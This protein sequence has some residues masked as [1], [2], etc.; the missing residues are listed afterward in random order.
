MSTVDDASLVKT[1]RRLLGY[2]QADLAKCL[3]AHIM[4]VSRWERNK[5]KLT[6]GYRILLRMLLCGDVEPAR[7]RALAHLDDPL[8]PPVS[9]D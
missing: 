9:S 5:A 4:T 8:S 1:V 7:V 6:G 3:N 2:S